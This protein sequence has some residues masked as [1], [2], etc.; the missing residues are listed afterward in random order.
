MWALLL[1]PIFGPLFLFLVV[2]P[3]AWLLY[4]LFPEGR[5]KTFLFRVRT[6]P[7]ATRRDGVVYA[8]W[9]IGLHAGLVALLV[10]IL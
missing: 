7:H 8:L 6:G 2:A 1:K 5:L 10:A 9:W 4:R 3:I